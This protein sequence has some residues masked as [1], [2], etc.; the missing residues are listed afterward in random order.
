MSRH[1]FSLKPARQS[2]PPP[3]N[4]PRPAPANCAASALRE[5]LTPGERAVVAA[6]LRR[7]GYPPAA[8]LAPTRGE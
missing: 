7:H 1:P 4:Q 5:P 6:I 2:G 3:A 8:P